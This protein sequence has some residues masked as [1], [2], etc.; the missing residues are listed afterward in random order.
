MKLVKMSIAA[1]L[2]LQASSFAIENVE[3][4]GAGK[5]FYAT[6]DGDGTSHW[7]DK[8][9]AYSQ[10]GL[11]LAVSADLGAGFK[12]NASLTGLATAGMKGDV[13]DSPWATLTTGNQLW[14]S[15]LSIAKNVTEK[16]SVKL[17]RQKLD[18]PF[19]FT[20]VWNLGVNT[21][22]AVL[23]ENTDISDT[24]LVGAYIDR[25]NGLDG[26]D[27]V[28]NAIRESG[29]LKDPFEKFMNNKGAYTVGAIN[30]SLPGTQ[31]QAWYY[32][33]DDTAK[34]YWLEMDSEYKGVV[35]GLQAAGLDMDEAVDT[36]KTSRGYAAK[37][38]YVG[39]DHLTLTA[40]VSQTSKDGSA[41]YRLANLATSNGPGNF[42]EQTKLYTEA[43]WNF[44]FVGKPGTT[45]YNATMLYTIPDTVDFGLFY[46]ASDQTTKD[47]D[48]DM[49]EIT[50][51]VA[52]HFGPLDASVAYIYAKN[53]LYNENQWYSTV[54]VYLT[55]HF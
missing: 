44:G 1:M 47:G 32:Q 46:T 17:G 26:F 54:Q 41:D 13:A 40:A 24:T 33:I 7:F 36:S 6:V 30:K 35:F 29:K 20:E 25:G 21:F 18:T 8:E 16:T 53:K 10:F 45:A 42:G 4:S 14:V 3:F 50:G 52:E 49:N 31:L 9:S 51:T 37:I 12:G 48:D 43:W 38:G 55:Y 19:I 28:N 15:E 11:D 34:A 2:V 5:F 39:V 22:D 23:I 27:S